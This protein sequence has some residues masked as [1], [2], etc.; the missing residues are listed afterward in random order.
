MAYRTLI[1]FH[2][3]SR[4]D[5][6]EIQELNMPGRGDWKSVVIRF[7]DA[8]GNPLDAIQVHAD[9]GEPLKITRLDKVD[10][11]LHDLD[12]FIVMAKEVEP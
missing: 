6:E 4:I 11:S 2:G 1:S 7:S 10:E 8:E 3:V 9:P 5:I 12:D